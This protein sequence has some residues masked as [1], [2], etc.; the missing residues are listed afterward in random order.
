MESF[1]AGNLSGHK[2]K[3]DNHRRVHIC[4]IHCVRTYLKKEGVAT[5]V[6]ICVKEHFP[7]WKMSTINI[8]SQ[9]QSDMPLVLP[10]LERQQLVT[11]HHYG[12]IAVTLLFYYTHI[13]S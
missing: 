3:A 4:K 11:S 1:I 12:L 7:I 10:T 6:A 13:R 8:H 9:K 5:Y 2:F